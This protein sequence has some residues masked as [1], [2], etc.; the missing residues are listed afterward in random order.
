MKVATVFEST[1][2]PPHRVL[3]ATYLLCTFKKGV[4]Q[5]CGK[6]HLHRDLNEFGFR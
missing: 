3:Q 4:Y 6:Q 2:I 5:Y 1:H